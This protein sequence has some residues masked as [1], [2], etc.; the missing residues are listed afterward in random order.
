MKFIFLFIFPLFLLFAC[1]TEN[2]S[3]PGD[4]HE[5]TDARPDNPSWDLP[6]DEL[7]PD[8]FGSI[9]GVV[10]SPAIS[11]QYRFPIPKALVYLDRNEPPM[12]PKRNY[13]DKCI[14]LPVA[15]PYDITDSY[16]AFSIDQVPA[17]DWNLVVQKGQFRRV[18]RITV[19]AGQNTEIPS[20][21]TSLP[22]RDDPAMMD[23]IPR[24]AVA[25]GVYDWFEDLL[26]KFGLADLGPD[27]RY[28][29]GT[30]EFTLFYNGGRAYGIGIEDFMDFLRRP[31]GT[32][33]E[34]DLSDFNILFIPC[35]NNHSDDVLGEPDVLENIRTFVKDGGK[36][37]VSDFSYDFVEQVFPDFIDYVGNDAVIGNAEGAI[38]E[39]WDT[40]GTIG[41][42]DL[43]AWLAALG[44]L[45]INLLENWVAIEGTATVA[46]QDEE[47]N[48]VDIVPAAMI[49]GNVP[50]Y[51]SKPLN[52]VFNYGCGK[53]FYTTYHTIGGHTGSA[54]PD[55]IAQE[56]ILLYL[57]LDIGVCTDHVVIPI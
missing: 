6:G 53:V 1:G 14:D 18:R 32:A 55:M 22:N 39:F 15:T 28:V 23:T 5:D 25:S 9:S 56:K 49:S 7:N 46:G 42:A 38:T 12:I 16:G 13:C 43:S 26:A 2:P 11:V 31:L 3:L 54:R 27:Y 17:G 10:F 57:V 50:S 48:P 24:I 37:Y 20:D 4:T 29:K 34:D 8:V 36:L 21:M 41:D 44:L 30:E 51:G 52:V 19:L 45:P 33:D 35:T 47:G 40:P